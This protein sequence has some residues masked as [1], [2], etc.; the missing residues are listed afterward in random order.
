MEIIVPVLIGVLLGAAMT[1]YLTLIDISGTLKIKT[2]QDE[3]DYL[4]LEL[5]KEVPKIINGKYVLFKVSP[6]E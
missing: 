4:F 3:V 1:L 6:R 5:S 2:D